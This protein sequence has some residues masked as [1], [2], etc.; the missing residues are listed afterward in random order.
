MKLS[1]PIFLFL[2]MRIVKGILGLI[3]KIYI[4]I[5]FTCTAIIMYPIIVPFLTSEK[6]KRRAFKLFVFWS[7][8]LSVL[9]FT[10][11]PKAKLNNVPAGPKLILANH[12]SYLDIFLMYCIFPDDR[13]L[14]LGKSELLSYPLIKT[15][16]KHYNIPVF[17]GTRIKAARSVI[18]AVEKIDKGWSIMIFPEGQIPD[19]NR[20]SM[21]PFKKGAFQIAKLS[22]T[23]ILPVTFVN[24]H[25]LFSIPSE[26]L[27]SA[28]P[29]ISKY[30]VHP[31]ITAD[32]V[33][34][35]DIEQLRE[36]CFNIINEPILQ[37]KK[38]SKQ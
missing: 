34:E 33:E 35:L 2:S 22:G 28:R 32:E 20:P 19:D 5:A 7:R 14:F 15:Y 29:G 24:N 23:P 16:F 4:A 9:I 17:R 36:K 10:Y 13:F 27:G 37:M 1:K 12:I 3:W 18:S 38:K 31:I 25:R 6:N 21:V 11:A 30:I 26:W 8:L